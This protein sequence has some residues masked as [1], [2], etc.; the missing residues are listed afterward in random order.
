MLLILN[1]IKTYFWL[2]SFDDEVQKHAKDAVKINVFYH[3]IVGKLVP[4]NLEHQHSI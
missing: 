3:F 4:F 2:Y 1:I